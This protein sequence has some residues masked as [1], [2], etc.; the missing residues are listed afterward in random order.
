MENKTKEDQ[1]VFDGTGDVTNFV[2]KVEIVATL[3]GYTEG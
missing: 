3:K 2:E 1:T